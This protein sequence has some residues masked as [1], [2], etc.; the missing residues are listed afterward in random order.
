MIRI[1]RPRLA[2]FADS[3]SRKKRGLGGYIAQGAKYGA[4]GGA[5]LGTGITLAGLR[6][7]LA[8]PEVANI[9]VGRKI[10]LAAATAGT[11]AVMK[12]VP[13]AAIGG[14]IGAGAYGVNKF[15]NRKK[16]NQVTALPTKRQKIAYAYNNLT[17]RVRSNG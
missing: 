14:V 4:A 12:A 3:Q 7:G 8:H 17:S 5:V 10:G 13:L 9:G 1:L 15:L 2:M 16:K 6:S 11:N